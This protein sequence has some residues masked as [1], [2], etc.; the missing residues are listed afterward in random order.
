MSFR[1]L[2]TPSKFQAFGLGLAKLFDHD[3]EERVRLEEQDHRLVL[4]IQ[5]CPVC[6]GR[7]ADESICQL[8]VGVAEESLYW[9][10]GGKIFHVEEVACAAK[11]D[12]ACILQIDETPLS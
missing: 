8:A 6:Q 1:L 5:G 12:P 9:L 3:G 2:P 10:S 7:Q 11:G 4:H